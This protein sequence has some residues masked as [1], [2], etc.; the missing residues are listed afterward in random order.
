MRSE[1]AQAR[2]IKRRRAVALAN[3]QALKIV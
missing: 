3:A 2:R 1:A